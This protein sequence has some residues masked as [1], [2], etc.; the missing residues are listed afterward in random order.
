MSR[1]AREQVKRGPY[2]P[3]AHKALYPYQEIKMSVKVSAAMKRAKTIQYIIHR[4]WE[5]REVRGQQLSL[6]S[7]HTC[8]GL[9]QL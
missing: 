1:S 9:T 8:P 7:Q 4:T 3:T 5:C 6:Q 2:L